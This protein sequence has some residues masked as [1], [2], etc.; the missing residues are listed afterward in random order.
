[1]SEKKREKCKH[2]IIDK[3][4]HKTK[5]KICKQTKHVDVK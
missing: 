4:I 2:S 3:Y 5:T 1:M